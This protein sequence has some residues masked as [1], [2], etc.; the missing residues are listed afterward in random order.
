MDIFG[1]TI[2]AGTLVLQFLGACS[3]YSDEAKSLE[4]RFDWDLRVLKAIRS[5]F[6]A[7]QSSNADGQL[8]PEDEALLDRTAAYLDGFVAMV[9]Q[10]LRKIERKRLL[11]S[12]F[13]RIMWMARRA[14]LQDMEKELLEWTE[15]LTRHFDV[16]VLGLPPEIRTILPATTANDQGAEPP[17]V[18]RSNKRLQE[19]LALAPSSKKA[20]ANK[21][22]LEDSTEV[23]SKIEGRRDISFLPM[24]NGSE[25]II[26]GARQ[27]PPNISE[28]TVEFQD[29]VSDMGELAAAL[30]CL[31][32]VAD[33]KLLK[34]EYYF[35]HTP[36]KQFLLAHHPPYPVLSMITLETMIR[37]E[38]FPDVAA[39]L[40]QCLKLG[41][42][43]AEAVFFLHTAGF[44][45]KN[46]TSTSV[47]ALRRA[48]GTE[49]DD[50]PDEAI[51][52]AYLMGFD[53]IRADTARTTKEGAVKD[54]ET[55]RSIWDFD[56]FQHPDRLRGADSPR[57]IKTYDVYSLG[58]VLLEIGFWKPLPDI[59]ERLNQGDPS[60]WPKALS[61]TL[62]VMSSRTGEKYQ[63]VV[64]WCLSLKGDQIVKD[65]EFT[66]RVLDPLEEL[67]DA[68]S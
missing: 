6:L 22:L 21:M 50:S 63:R 40:N 48:R 31:D 42:K 20:L 27:K 15:R 41:Y 19:F 2:T 53:L 55:P 66:E 16:R 12:T 25:Q 34:V 5:H 37:E 13:N 49:N 29:L 9:Q 14:D 17:A 24:Q 7:R 68:L 61:G 54:T 11:K 59:V 45:H 39:P 38:P 10:S 18:V 4:A 8:S 33:I 57:Y 65:S 36:S 67:I 52:E 30:N 3:A 56:V 43:L 1:T 62:E 46:I 26:F 28:G 47:V 64:A 51:D 44:I 35:Y 32:P 23:A 60:S 58:V